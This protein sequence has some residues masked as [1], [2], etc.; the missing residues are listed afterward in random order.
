M[1]TKIEDL[2]ADETAAGF[3]IKSAADM[4]E[5]EPPAPVPEPKPEPAQPPP[6]PVSD[7]RI[8]LKPLKL[9]AAAR[10]RYFEDDN[11]PVQVETAG[12]AMAHVASYLDKDAALGGYKNL[13]A[14]YPQVLRLEPSIAHEEVPGRGL[15]YRLYLIGDRNALASLCSEMHTLNDWCLVVK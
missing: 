8:I 13:S 5:E 12:I 7:G 2:K 15:F 6:L 10:R 4:P 14:K 1:Q 3:E 11:A 9:D